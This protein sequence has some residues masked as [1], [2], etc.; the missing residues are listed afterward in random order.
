MTKYNHH[1]LAQPT[2]TGPWI[3]AVFSRGDMHET[4]GP[5]DTRDDA[6]AWAMTNT[7]PGERAEPRPL[8]PPN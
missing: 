2:P 8:T 1:R 4:V 6:I 5:F 3:I 7:D